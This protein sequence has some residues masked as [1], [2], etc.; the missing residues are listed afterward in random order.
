MALKKKDSLNKK[1]LKLLKTIAKKPYSPS[2]IDKEYA[3][4]VL[5]KVDKLRKNLGLE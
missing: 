1:D 4:I 5:S 2:N 3:M